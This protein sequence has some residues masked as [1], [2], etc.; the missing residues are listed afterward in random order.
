MCLKKL[1]YF[2]ECLRLMAQP[3]G[4]SAFWTTTCRVAREGV[5]RSMLRTI[6]FHRLWGADSN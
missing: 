4:S 3:D 5:L 1:D 2:T 6:S